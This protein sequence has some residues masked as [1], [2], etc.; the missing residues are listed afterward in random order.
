MKVTKFASTTVLGDHNVVESKP[1]S[2]TTNP[3]S[4]SHLMTR[5]WSWV[6][7]TNSPSQ[8]GKIINVMVFGL[9]YSIMYTLSSNPKLVTSMKLILI[10]FMSCAS[11]PYLVKILWWEC[12]A[13]NLYRHFIVLVCFVLRNLCHIVFVLDPL[14]SKLPSHF[15]LFLTFLW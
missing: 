11:S 7:R 10:F 12:K 13:L 3:E 15:S 8:M 9:P 6:L 2:V 1:N 4:W 5:W 14:S